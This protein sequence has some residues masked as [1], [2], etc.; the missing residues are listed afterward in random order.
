MNDEHIDRNL[1]SFLRKAGLNNPSADFT[2]SVME[3]IH[4]M[5]VE[6][7]QPG[8]QTDRF[9]EWVLFSSLGVTGALAITWYF[10]TYS[11]S[12]FFDWPITEY[13]PLLKKLTDSLS[14]IFSS[15]QVS[16]ITVAVIGAILLVFIAD[17]II[18][19]LQS[20]RKNYIL[21]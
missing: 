14:A 19:K 2:Q 11:S 17:M 4:Q 12:L 18:A 10:I 20:D 1:K 7:I 9:K 21:L 16:S 3:K 5:P 15:F 8:M 13:W 6:K